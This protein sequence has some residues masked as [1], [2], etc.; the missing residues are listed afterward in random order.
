[1]FL[2][3]YLRYSHFPLHLANSLLRLAVD[4]KIVMCVYPPNFFTKRGEYLLFKI[5]KPG[6][7]LCHSLEMLW[8]SYLFPN[9]VNWI[10]F[11]GSL[12]SSARDLV[13]LL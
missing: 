5:Q 1:M 4:G 7:M 6:F 9:L 8:C 13:K 3:W 11:F 2:F 12:V 10:I